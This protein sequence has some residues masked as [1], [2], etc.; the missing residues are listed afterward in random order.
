[1]NDAIIK[2]LQET[3]SLGAI[4]IWAVPLFIGALIGGI[5][6]WLLKNSKAIVEIGKLKAEIQN[7]NA[8]AATSEGDILVH[9]QETKNK[10]SLNCAAC[11][12]FV[13]ALNSLMKSSTASLAEVDEARERLADN[14]ANDTIPSYCDACEWARLDLHINNAPMDSYE[15][16]LDDIRS[17]LDRFGSWLAAINSKSFLEH[18]S[19]APLRLELRTFRPLLTAFERYPESIRNDSLLIG[20]TAVN[21]LCATAP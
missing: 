15:T 10:Y 7:L 4:S 5:I 19:K 14:F 16:L 12:R 21:T 13:A 8:E 6:G 20:R 18:L 2:L 1:M 3:G 9:K 17:E 11:G